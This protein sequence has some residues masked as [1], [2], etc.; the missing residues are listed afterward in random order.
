MVHRHS[1]IAPGQ[2]RLAFLYVAISAPVIACVVTYRTIAGLAWWQTLLLLIGGLI[3]AWGTVFSFLE[4]RRIAQSPEERAEEALKDVN[5]YSSRD[6]VVAPPTGDP[7][8]HHEDYPESAGFD[9]SQLTSRLPD[10]TPFVGRFFTRR[11]REKEAVR[12]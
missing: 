10:E 2:E 12:R 1:L 11:R 5:P 7:C 3:G 9:Q 8:P 4:F 6:V